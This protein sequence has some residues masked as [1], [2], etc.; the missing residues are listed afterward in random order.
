MCYTHWLLLLTILYNI[1][2]VV[3]FLW[4]L[5]VFSSFSYSLQT[6]YAQALYPINSLKKFFHEEA[7]ERQRKCRHIPGR[8]IYLRV[9]ATVGGS[10]LTPASFSRGPHLA[11]GYC[12]RITLSP[13]GHFCKLAP[14]CCLCEQAEA[15][16]LLKPFLFGW[17]LSSPSSFASYPQ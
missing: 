4:H 17:L 15:S 16:L 7:T 9:V 6:C 12:V 11:D 13:R 2:L 8:H 3:S 5:C 14:Q 10:Q 1:V